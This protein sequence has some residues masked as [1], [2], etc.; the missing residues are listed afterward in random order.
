[1]I[2]KLIFTHEGGTNLFNIITK[3][4]KD[5]PEVDPLLIAGLVEAIA[6]FSKEVSQKDEHI[7]SF[8]ETNLNKFEY[9]E[10]EDENRYAIFGYNKHHIREGVI[11]K[12]KFI[13]DEYIRPLDIA[14]GEHMSDKE[15]AGVVNNVLLDLPLKL[16]LNNNKESIDSILEPIL[17]DGYTAAYALT[18]SDNT[19]LHYKGKDKEAI[20][21]FLALCKRNSVPQRLDYFFRKD[22]ETG[23]DIKELTGH[24]II[25][26]VTN[27]CINLPHE[28]WNEVL[29]YFFTKNHLMG[30]EVERKNNELF[31][32]S[33]EWS[34]ELSLKIKP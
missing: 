2:S 28:P 3:S 34:K 4:C 25:G 27:T 12:V 29:L 1:M 6:C 20:K 26:Y 14:I 24:E 9:L 30:L 32:S 21:R 16:Y 23:I 10:L 18:S 33:H 22:L 11:K 8:F 13:Y 7:I 5:E 17:N 19:I 15:R 31:E